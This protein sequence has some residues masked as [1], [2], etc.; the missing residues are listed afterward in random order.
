MNDM[1]PDTET[2]SKPSA[3]DP[4]SFL[5]REYS[6]TST[7]YLEVESRMHDVLKLFITLLLGLLAASFTFA[8]VFALPV[9]DPPTDKVVPDKV[10]LGLSAVWL[11]F[12]VLS[13][14]L[15]H[16]FIE[17]RVR[18][19]RFLEQIVAIRKAVT[20]ASPDIS[21][22][23][24]LISGVEKAPPYLRRP[25][26]E[27]YGIIYMSLTSGAVLASTLAALSW[28]FFKWPPA[29]LIPAAVVIFTGYTLICYGSIVKFAYEHD[30]QRQEDIGDSQY[31]FLRHGEIP[32]R[33]LRVFDW[34]AEQVEC[35]RKKSIMSDEGVDNGK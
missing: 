15:R 12:L 10:W 17:L 14:L 35:R 19:I 33:T 21:S 31:E 20:D 2:S 1:A 7:H 34:I 3:P 25:S 26:A 18:K 27:W 4:S 30:L 9:G 6:E 28:V 8:Q 11:G 23:L 32:I 16:Y 24:R 13:S 29:V 5:S 22:T